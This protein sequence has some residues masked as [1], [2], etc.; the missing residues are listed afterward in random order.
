MNSTM[1]ND[2]TQLAENKY[3]QLDGTTSGG[4]PKCARLGILLEFQHCAESLQGQLTGRPT[5]RPNSVE[6]QL[7]RSSTH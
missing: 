2:R 4:L 3:H 6:V 5:G 1:E 7:T